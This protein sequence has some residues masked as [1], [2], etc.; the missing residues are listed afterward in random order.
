MKNNQFSSEHENSF[1]EIYEFKMQQK[2]FCS[3][4]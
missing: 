3:L 2:V 1:N 4:I